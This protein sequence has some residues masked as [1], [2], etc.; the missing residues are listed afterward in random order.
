MR[1]AFEF[2]F[3]EHRGQARCATSKQLMR[4][5]GRPTDIALLGTSTGADRLEALVLGRHGKQLAQARSMHALPRSQSA[6]A[7]QALVGATSLGKHQ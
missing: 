1:G 3:F 4:Y 2:G 6:Q 7:P 5:H